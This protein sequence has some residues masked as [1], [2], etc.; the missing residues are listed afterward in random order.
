M[1]LFVEDISSGSFSASTFT[2]VTMTAETLALSAIT[3]VSLIQLRTTSENPAYSEG[4]LFYDNINKTLSYYNDTSGVTMNVGQE[5]WIRVKNNS[6][7]LIANGKIVYISGSDTDGIPFVAL[8]KSDSEDT[9]HVAGVATHDISNGE[10]GYITS[11]GVVHDINTSAFSTGQDLYLSNSIAGNFASSNEILQGFRVPIGSVLSS[12]ATTGSTLITIGPHY[13]QTIKSNYVIVRSLSD[14]PAPISN[15]ISLSGNTIYEIDGNVNFEDNRIVVGDNTI[16]LGENF[17]HDYMIY[18]GT[19]PFITS[20]NNNFQVS[21]LHITSIFGSVFALTGNS[22]TKM[23]AVYN[24]IDSCHSIGDFNGGEVVFF[25]NNLIKSL[26][27]SGVT[28]TGSL[29][30]PAFEANLVEDNNNGTIISIPS[31]TFRTIG[32]SQN[33]FDVSSAMTALNISS[34]ITLDEGVL[35]INSFN[36]SGTYVSG[37]TKG[38]DRWK[39]VGNSGLEDSKTIAN[40]YVVGNTTATV[41]GSTSLYYKASGV[42]SADVLERFSHDSNL[43]RLTYT[44]LRPTEVLILANF[45][46]TTTNNNQTIRGII[47]IN[48]TG[49]T[50]TENEIRI[51]TGGQSSAGS[52]SGSFVLQPNDYVEFFV[53][54]ITGTNNILVENLSININ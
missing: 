4:K 16:L 51:E 23:S 54:N 2:A 50:K 53:R 20:I 6:G 25:T 26:S 39:F 7:S 10:T 14:L 38:T 12:H 27:N 48:G 5:N 42:T 49:S 22:S 3:D 43:R 24:F 45:S 37:I 13:F 33:I 1:S 44:G 35:S 30:F 18:S 32:I 40:M 15:V 29:D 21:N 9:S 47:A 36:G 8:A 52:C 17:V 34:G 11:F 28:F 41:I 31:G 46:M 19:Q